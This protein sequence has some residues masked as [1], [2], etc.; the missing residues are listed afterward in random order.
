MNNMNYNQKRHIELL[1]RAENFKSQKKS[2][3]KENPEEYLELTK[4]STAVEQHIFWEDRFEVASLIQDFLNKK[5][6]G[7]E[8]HD[9]V[10]GL[11]RKLIAKCDKFLSKLVSEKVKDF[12][13][14]KK[15][16]KL[17]GFLTFLYFEC[18]HFEENF[19]NEEFY[20]SIR[21]GFL[22]FQ[23]ILNEE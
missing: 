15:S 14:N 17:K 5:M 21:N 19:E 11:R 20:T 1:K 22:K 9:S 16:N 2:F 4:Y 8:F 3:F 23:E 10:F 6:N 13:P 18:E 7:E 12:Y